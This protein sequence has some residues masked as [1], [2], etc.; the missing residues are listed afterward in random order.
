MLSI[1]IGELQK[2]T[3]IFSNLTEVIEII[4]KRSKRSLAMVYPVKKLSIITKLAGKYRNRIENSNV[5]MDE[6]REIAM[7]TA[8]EEK[9]GLSS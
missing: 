9:Y 2:N 3:S 7:R 1:G 6:I 5:S 4:D 8:M